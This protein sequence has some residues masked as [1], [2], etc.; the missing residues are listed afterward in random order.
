MSF[1]V[2]WYIGTT[3]LG[4]QPTARNIATT[5]RQKEQF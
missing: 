4:E 5:K 1:M 2:T 3:R